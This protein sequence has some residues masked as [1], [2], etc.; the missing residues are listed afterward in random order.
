[1]WA[2]DAR[3]KPRATTDVAHDSSVAHDFSRAIA[4]WLLLTLTSAPIAFAQT[5]AGPAIVLR[6]AP[7]K[8]TVRAARLQAPLK[9]DGRLDEAVY[10]SVEPITGFIQQEPREGE[11]AT[12]V[13]ATAATR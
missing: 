12:L 5:N 1:M 2:H 10:E 7:D 6:T 13:T 8:V 9:I 3:L 4:I 11:P